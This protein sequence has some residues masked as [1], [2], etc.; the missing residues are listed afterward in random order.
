[1]QTQTDN[2]RP[3]E[4]QG[5]HRRGK[6]KDIRTETALA[7][8]E[9]IEATE[10]RNER[11]PASLPLSAIRIANQVFQWRLEG[12]DLLASDEHIRELMR[13]AT[14]QEGPLDPVLVT[15]IGQSYYLIDGHHRIAAYRSLGWRE[16]VPVAYFE[17]SLHEAVQEA[18]RQN[19][20]GQLPLTTEAKFEAAWS[21]V[22]Q[23]RLKANQIR[24]L[25][26]IS[27]RTIVTMNKKLKDLGEG[28]ESVSWAEAR[29]RNW[30]PDPDSDWRTEKAQKI[31]NAIL[32]N[33]GISLARDP[34]L[35]A[36]ALPLVNER[37]PDFLI[38]AWAPRVRPLMEKHPDEFELSPLD[39]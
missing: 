23:G 2:V 17:G 25:T 39:I 9:A 18:L 27:R 11:R 15:P 36:E 3:S 8:L 29:R 20:K 1:M 31:A 35:L 32:R 13:S 26:T 4:F 6:L 21:L 19:V 28:A 7:D 12:H 30:E 14:A 38:L 33:T 24:A 22:K 37:L 34:R 10:Q 5:G 16:S